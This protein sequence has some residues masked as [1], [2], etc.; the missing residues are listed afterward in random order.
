[1]LSSRYSGLPYHLSSYDLETT[2]GSSHRRTIVNNVYDSRYDKLA[3]SKRDDDPEHDV[4]D[5]KE[6]ESI[7]VYYSDSD[8]EHEAC[9]FHQDLE[10]QQPFN[11]DINANTERGDRRSN[12]AYDSLSYVPREFAFFSKFGSIDD[13][14]LIDEGDIEL[15]MTFSEEN[16]NFR[17]HMRFESKQQ[18]SRAIRM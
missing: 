5:V 6:S 12:N 18:F 7:D 15:I 3:A 16:N 9:D 8:D 17:L 10:S 13:D 4:E 14:D 11:D 1:M 2:L